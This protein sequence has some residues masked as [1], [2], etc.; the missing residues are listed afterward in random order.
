MSRFNVFNCTEQKMD[1]ESIR[2]LFNDDEGFT[3]V[4]LMIVVAIIGILAAIA[5]P[6]F[7]KYMK[8]SKAAEAEQ[9]MRKMSDGAK[10]YFTSE[11]YSCKDVTDA[12][13]HPWHTSAAKGMP[14]GFSSKV[15]PGGTDFSYSTTGTVPK[16]GSKYDPDAISGET[17]TAALNKMNLSLEDPLYFQ[18]NFDTGSSAGTNATATIEAV[19]DFETGSSGSGSGSGG[20]GNAHTVTQEL[21][22]NGQEVTVGQPVTTN[23]FK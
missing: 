9:I 14:V 12:C 13:E 3:L 7:M 18:Y 22:V 2:N 10:S 19:H 11:Q 8:S 1:T 6:S 16:G 20:G 17:E 23:E 15:F 4:E 5:I 21:G